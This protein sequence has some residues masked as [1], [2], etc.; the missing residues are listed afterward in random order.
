MFSYKHTIEQKKCFNKNIKYMINQIESNLNDIENLENELYL[1]IS[2]KQVAENLKKVL[3]MIKK[4]PEYFTTTNNI[5]SIQQ[6]YKKVE[7]DISELELCLADYDDIFHLDGI[8]YALYQ[9]G[10]LLINILNAKDSKYND[11]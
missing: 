8:S 3:S 6:E 4:W 9:I 2:K 7:S 5:N 10:K 1:E 11:R